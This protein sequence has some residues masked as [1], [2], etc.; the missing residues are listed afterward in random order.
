MGFWD[1]ILGIS[2]Y[3]PAQRVLPEPYEPFFSTG[4]IPVMDPGSPLE[5]WTHTHVEQF[6]RSQPALRK[7]VGFVAR[8]VASIPLHTYERV[9]DNERQRITDHP[10]PR[11][12]SRPQPHVG[13]FRFW[14][15]VISDG[16]LYDRWA[17]MKDWQDDDSLH[18]V[19]L[20]SWRLHFQLDPLRRV[21]G[22][23]VWV[24]D[25]DITEQDERGWLPVPLDSLI[26]DHGYAPRTAGLSPV[27]TLKD[28]LDEG[29][30]AVQYRRDVWRNG[31]RASQT[32]TR[33]M[34]AQWTPE[35]RTRF[36]EG[37]RKFVK[38]GA[39]SGGTMLLED[40]M[41]LN[42][43]QTMTLTDA[44][45]LQGR[46]L[47]SVEVA[48]AFYVAPELIGI[49]EGNFSNVD[50]FRQSLY[51][52]S[53]GPYITAWEQA[54]N[55]GLT[56]EMS[57]GANLYVEANIES[58]LRGSFQEQAQIMQSATGAPWMSR[59]EARSRLNMPP[60]EGG[61]EIVTPLNVLIG[62]QSSPNDGQTAGGGGALVGRA[63]DIRKLVDAAAVLI[64]S[65]FEP[66]AALMA[67][68]LDPIEHLGLLPVTV[69]RPLDPDGDV[70]EELQDA[71]KHD[72]RLLSKARSEFEI[73]APAE[74]EIPEDHQRQLEAVFSKFFGRQR[75]AVLS[76]AG[77]K[78]AAWW[79]AA[80]WDEELA[81]DLLTSGLSVSTASALAVLK[82]MGVDPSE[83]S[84]P[85]TKAFLAK[86][87]ERISK[88]VNAT[89]YNALEAAF[90][91]GDPDAV[92][93][94]F[95]VAEESRSAQSG[96][97]AAATFVGFGLVEGPRQTRPKARKRW[98]V[99]S[100]NPRNSH[101]A[102]NGEEVGIDEE[103]SNGLPWPGSFSG[104]VEEVA[105]C[106]CSVVI[107]T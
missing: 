102:L 12:L 58:K 96:M 71:L 39:A 28:L 13:A 21:V 42:D 73:K 26:F 34:E 47:T 99:N 32:I 94:V 43:H 57:N 49:R 54:I 105:N 86:V 64:R 85:R 80:R 84:Q 30:E 18:L 38:G 51:R 29:S 31:G 100:G 45:D 83:Y 104:D 16:L 101:A 103:F 79:D 48:S 52:D 91:S 20:P 56:A 97:T 5:M 1:R 4:G 81:D 27:E 77:A 107:I 7:V 98:Q 25:S 6:W 66:G 17:V 63:D 67:V 70:D 76:A 61:D 19:H 92:S 93:H 14:E 65:G 69:Q 46:E 11:T 59:N 15:S 82:D 22:A 24:G 10:L 9:S 95:D 41:T 23:R 3:D 78:S 36:V 50:A 72:P 68:G 44:M 90:E 2:S 88:Q 35:Q 53:L 8:N 33:P 74:G 75:K 55:V 106:Q 40:G 60:I 87:A 89:T 62:G 37:L